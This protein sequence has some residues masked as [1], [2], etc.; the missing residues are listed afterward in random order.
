MRLIGDI[1]DLFG[2]RVV[3]IDSDGEAC[4]RA[5][6]VDGKAARR[7]CHFF[8]PGQARNPEDRAAGMALGYQRPTSF[9]RNVQQNCFFPGAV[10]PGA[11][12]RLTRA[13]LSG[14]KLLDRRFP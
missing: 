10:P 11:V 7:T 9:P 13:K 3:K 12:H 6:R 8:F 2:Q 14:Q 5:G 1:G 4:R